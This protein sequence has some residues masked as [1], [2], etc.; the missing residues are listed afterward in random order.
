MIHESYRRWVIV[1]AV[2]WFMLER[3][4]IQEPIPGT[5]LDK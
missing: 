4:D 2:I 3:R 1:S 5:S